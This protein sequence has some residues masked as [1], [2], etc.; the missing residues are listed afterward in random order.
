MKFLIS[1]FFIPA[2]L[3]AHCDCRYDRQSE[4][5][6]EHK[7]LLIAEAQFT[8]ILEILEKNSQNISEDDMGNFIYHISILQQ[9]I[10]AKIH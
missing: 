1:L 2:L 5:H 7:R 6:L 3:S 8:Q 10:Q 9:V 4:F